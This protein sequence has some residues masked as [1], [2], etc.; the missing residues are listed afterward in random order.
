MNHSEPDGRPKIVPQCTLPLT[1]LDA[2]DLVIT[3]LAVFGFD[4]GQLR[5]VELMPGAQLDEVRAKTGV[6]FR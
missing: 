5:L 4:G 3:D 6:P 1:A 2:V